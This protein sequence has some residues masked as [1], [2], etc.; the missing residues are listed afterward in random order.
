MAETKHDVPRV[1][2]EH[3]N[4][5]VASEVVA[6]GIAFIEPLLRAARD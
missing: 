2:P 4:P 5:P 3:F 6:R 1:I